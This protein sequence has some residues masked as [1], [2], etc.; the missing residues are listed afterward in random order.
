M[1]K[2]EQGDILQ[3]QAKAK[4][5]IA[6]TKATTPLTSSIA[7]GTS[8]IEVTLPAAPEDTPLYSL[9]QEEGSKEASSLFW[10][11]IDKEDILDLY[12]GEQETKLSVPES[13]PE[14][15]GDSEERT[16]TPNIPVDV[17]K[18]KDKLG[19]EDLPKKES[20]TNFGQK[21]NTLNTFNKKAGKYEDWG[22]YSNAETL[23][24]KKN[25]EDQAKE[26][27]VFH[28]KGK[29]LTWIHREYLV[30]NTLDLIL[31]KLEDT[32][33][34]RNRSVTYA[35][36]NELKQDPKETVESYTQRFEMEAKDIYGPQE[37]MSKALSYVKGLRKDLYFKVSQMEPTDFN[38]AVKLA[39]IQEKK[40]SARDAYDRKPTTRPG[41]L[42]KTKEEPVSGKSEKKIQFIKRD[43]ETELELAVKKILE[44]QIPKIVETT[45]KGMQEKVKN[46]NQN[47]NKP[48]QNNIQERKE[49]PTCE[50]CSRKGHLAVHCYKKKREDKK[51]EEET[52]TKKETETKVNTED[53][54]K[55]KN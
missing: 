19:S 22:Y 38:V 25:Y 9:S 33:E 10:I 21:N 44:D 15:H 30:N 12:E 3:S 27:L 31:Q 39:K 52:Q 17:D 55:T 28:L 13:G 54:V 43:D 24:W 4:E 37:Q 53:S 34:P 35:L 23:K 11:P 8:P 6:K 50:Y 16:E 20:I 32:F 14:Y 40:V 5:D 46:I 45:V 42:R 26:E 47:S 41:I 48:K 1:K 51:K 36:I 29:V 2:R 7:P 49:K 18:G